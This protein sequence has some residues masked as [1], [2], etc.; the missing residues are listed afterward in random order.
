MG[1]ASVAGFLA[2]LLVG[3]LARAQGDSAGSSRPKAL[4][5]ALG[6]RSKGD[7]DEIQRRRMLRALVVYSRSLFFIDRGKQRGAT[8][9][10]LKAFEDEVNAHLRTKTL[11]FQ[12]VFIPVPRDQ[13]IPAL[14]DGRGDIAAASLSIT[15]ERER[16]V[17]FS[18]P[19][20]EGVS[21]VV[22][23]GPSGPRIA[24]VEDLS[25]QAVH[26][27]RSSSYWEHLEALN[28]RLVAGG[29][30]PV[31]LVPVS[32][33]L[34]DE[35]LLEM[36]NAGLIPTTVCDDFY[37]TFWKRVYSKLVFDPAIAV[38]SGGS[39][40]WMMRKN[41]PQLKAVTDA[42]VRK[43]RKGTAF[44]NALLRR[45]QGNLRSVLPATSGRELRKFEQT[46]ELF[47]K[48]GQQ[49]DVDYLLVMAQGYQES[50][51]D[52]QVISPA[53]A[54]GI[55]QIMPATGAQMKVGDI[56]NLEPNIHAGVK[57]LRHVEDSYFD[58]PGLDP[59]VKALF[60]FASYNAGPN[61]IQSL[62][63]EAARR[64]LDPNRW[65]QHVEV[66]VAERIG[67]ETVTYVSNIFKYYVAY[68]LVAEAQQDRAM[69]RH[70]IDPTDP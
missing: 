68:Q 3:T 38:S 58:E 9:E 15:P 18:A 33:D 57:Y 50:R 2:L 67:Q 52:Q 48:Y 63:R 56:R 53:G 11:R 17:G 4:E 45:Y 34:E 62:R 24:R 31:K 43:H 14:L 27:R 26:V 30:P 13:L 32:E 59:L 70:P 66:V 10:M 19:V 25:G 54:I 51:L 23:T 49:Y 37:A 36:V 1:R 35:D 20:L 41:S 46:V 6:E 64:G 7:W 8:Y 29:R 60:A 65:F 55:M 39:V 16:L 21:E 5:Q 61:R 69:A 44:G 40:A 47:R 12:V 22:V 28:R 42:F